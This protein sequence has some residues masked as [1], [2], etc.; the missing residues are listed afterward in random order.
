MLP[1]RLLFSGVL[2]HVERSYHGCE[3]LPRRGVR[4]HG[5]MCV[6]KEISALPWRGGQRARAVRKEYVTTVR[7]ALPWRVCYHGEDVSGLGLAVPRPRVSPETVVLA[8]DES[9]LPPTQ[10]CRA[11]P[12]GKTTEETAWLSPWVKRM[13]FVASV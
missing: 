13:H 6:T 9:P 4:C 11:E 8:E 1:R 10:P 3:E 2:S 7:C 5:E 12:I